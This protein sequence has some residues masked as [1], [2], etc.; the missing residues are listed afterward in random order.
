MDSDEDDDEGS[1]VDGIDGFF[2]LY[3]DDNVENIDNG[4]ELVILFDSGSRE[5]LSFR[6]VFVFRERRGVKSFDDFDSD[7]EREVFLFFDSEDEGEENDF[8][9][10][11]VEVVESVDVDFVGGYVYD[12]LVEDVNDNDDE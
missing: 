7:S 1:D 6:R 2:L 11:V 12:L 8:R 9:S 3:S 5:D 4:D 10:F